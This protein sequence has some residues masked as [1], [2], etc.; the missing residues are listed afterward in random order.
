VTPR[1][2]G[3][4]L[5]LPALTVASVATLVLSSYLVAVYQ[6]G[7]PAGDF[8]ELVTHTTTGKDLAVCA[9]KSVFFGSFICTISCYCGYN[10]ESG[11]SG[12]GSATNKAVVVSAVSCAIVNYFIS[13][14][15]YG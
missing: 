15:M 2:L 10:S 4:V 13:E 6:L 9:L 5:V 3:I 1:F 8:I 7:L 14:V 11:P 12:V